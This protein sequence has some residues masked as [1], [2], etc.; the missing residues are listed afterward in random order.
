MKSW[1]FVGRYMKSLFFPVRAGELMGLIHL[2][3][4]TGLRYHDAYYVWRR[5]YKRPDVY[6]VIESVLKIAAYR[7]ISVQQALKLYLGQL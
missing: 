2:A 5:F 6:V 7:G 4:T 1:Q 3:K